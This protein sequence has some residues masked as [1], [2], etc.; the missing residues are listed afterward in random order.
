MD[1]GNGN[2]TM[3][4]QLRFLHLRLG[5]VLGS[6][7]EGPGEFKAIPD[8]M[9]PCLKHTVY[10]LPLL[11]DYN[12]KIHKWKGKKKKENFNKHLFSLRCEKPRSPLCCPRDCLPQLSLMRMQVL[13][14]QH[15]CIFVSVSSKAFETGGSWQG[16]DLYDYHNW[17]VKWTFQ[18]YRKSVKKK[19]KSQP[20]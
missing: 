1:G 12:F 9:R 3:G 17:N 13:L 8:S 10:I 15:P 2:R 16:L 11:F 19:K 4:K 18:F 14:W 7:V 20:S 6:E 5:C